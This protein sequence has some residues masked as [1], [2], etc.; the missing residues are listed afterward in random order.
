MHISLERE[1]IPPHQGES[2][3]NLSEH[4][5]FEKCDECRVEF[6]EFTTETQRTQ[7]KAGLVISVSSVSLW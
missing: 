7:R 5:H 6:G 2:D 3:M 4:A 1:H